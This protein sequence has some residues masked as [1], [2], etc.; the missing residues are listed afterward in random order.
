MKLLYSQTRL[1]TTFNNFPFLLF[2][3]IGTNLVQKAQEEFVKSEGRD[4]TTGSKTLSMMELA[5]PGLHFEQPFRE[6]FLWA[7]LM[8]RQV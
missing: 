8:N 5:N 7:V 1:N 2:F 6:L 4:F 3:P